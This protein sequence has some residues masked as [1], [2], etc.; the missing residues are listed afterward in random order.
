ML[1]SDVCQSRGRPPPPQQPSRSSN[2]ARSR[3]RDIDEDSRGGG[4]SSDTHRESFELESYDLS[5]ASATLSR[6]ERLRF[7][8]ENEMRRQNDDG[9]DHEEKDSSPPDH[10]NHRPAI[11]KRK[12]PAPPPKG[13]QPRWKSPN[14]DSND[15]TDEEKSQEGDVGN[16]QNISSDKSVKKRGVS[17]ED[18][19]DDE[20]VLTVNLDEDSDEEEKV[21]FKVS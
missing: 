10:E 3:S 16:F 5:K 9:D 20:P 2:T 6:E 12:K 15:S 11:V 21:D 4:I 8:K 13:P 18:L 1:L 7:S 19:I 14:R 17:M